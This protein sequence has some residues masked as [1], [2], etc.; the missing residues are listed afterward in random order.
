MCCEEFAVMIR[1]SEAHPAIISP[2][3]TDD[4]TPQWRHHSP[5]ARDRSHVTQVA[6]TMASIPAPLAAVL[7]RDEG[8]RRTGP[9]PGD[10]DIDVRLPPPR[11]EQDGGPCT[12]ERATPTTAAEHPTG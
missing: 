2:P 6:S 11:M 3:P 7:R 1:K 5:A 10:D 8:K 9:E 12:G 4:T